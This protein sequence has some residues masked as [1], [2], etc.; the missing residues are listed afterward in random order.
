MTPLDLTTLTPGSGFYIMYAN[1]IRRAY[2]KSVN[3]SSYSEYV[4]SETGTVTTT[5]DNI[6]AIYHIV[7][8]VDGVSTTGAYSGK[9]S[10]ENNAST[11]WVFTGF[12]SNPVG[13]SKEDVIAQL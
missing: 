6:Y 11:A 12:E 13:L 7:D 4:E 3:F 1:A 8:D 9:R 10:Y 5:T 2:V